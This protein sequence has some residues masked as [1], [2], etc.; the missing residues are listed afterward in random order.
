ML[1]GIATVAITGPFVG[2]A[3]SQHSAGD[4]LYVSSLMPA[5]S[6]MAGRSAAPVQLVQGRH[7]SEYGI[8]PPK[9]PDYREYYGLG[10]PAY[11]P[12]GN[13]G[14]IE[15]Y[16]PYGGRHPSSYGDANI[17]KYRPCPSWTTD[18]YKC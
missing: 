10:L 17:Y 2:S 1:V 14:N 8:V 7:F 3:I 13:A 15:S 4:S 12:Y 5:R 9:A 6:E 18:P 11:P 16:F